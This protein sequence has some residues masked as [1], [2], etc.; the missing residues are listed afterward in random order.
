MGPLGG[1]AGALDH[2]ARHGFASVLTIACDMPYLPDGLLAAI[3]REAC[4]YCPDVP[5]LGHWPAALGGRL[6]AH[7]ETAPNRSIRG[8][9]EAVRATPV[10]ALGAIPNVN[11]LADL[12]R[13]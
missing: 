13:L 3:A 6:L 1:I 11:T 4:A 7:I 10:H 2:A 8:W 9:A 5:V 12:E